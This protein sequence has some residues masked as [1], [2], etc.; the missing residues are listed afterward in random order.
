VFTAQGG[1]CWGHIVR[2]K[3]LWASFQERI[4][5]LKLIIFHKHSS[6]KLN[7]NHSDLHEQTR[8]KSEAVLLQP[9]NR[10]QSDT[11]GRRSLHWM[12]WSVLGHFTL[13]MQN[14]FRTQINYDWTIYDVGVL[15]EKTKRTEGGEAVITLRRQCLWWEQDRVMVTHGPQ[16]WIPR[17]HVSYWDSSSSCRPRCAKY[18]V[19][20][21]SLGVKG[22]AVPLHAMEAL[23]GREGIAPT[24]SRP[25]H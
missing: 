13:R 8:S 14:L 10:S 18:I 15:N 1:T 23:G 7:K 20:I 19:D 24:H 11:F 21:G 6:S 4:L 2:L 16:S 12:L 25:R 9:S 22:K 17:T 3:V 5:R